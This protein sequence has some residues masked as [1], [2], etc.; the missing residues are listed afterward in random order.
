MT[1][2]NETVLFNQCPIIGVP[3]FLYI[4]SPYYHEDN[5][6]VIDRVEKVTEVVEFFS[7]TKEWIFPY[8]PVMYAHPIELNGKR[9]KAGNIMYGLGAL[10]V[11]SHMMVLMLDGWKKSEGIAKEIAFCKGKDIPI[12]YMTFEN[13]MK[14]SPAFNHF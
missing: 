1:N 12:I 4:A 10:N 11:A 8:S 2:N 3:K 13:V 5:D 14:D 7:V 9:P 6:V